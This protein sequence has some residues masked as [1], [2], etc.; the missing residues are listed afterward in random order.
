MHLCSLHFWD[1][2]ANGVAVVRSLRT[3]DSSIAT[4]YLS[5]LRGGSDKND[6]SEPSEILP[7]DS[8]GN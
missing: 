6:I 2:D 5:S 3:R 7:I 1:E 8:E 4:Q